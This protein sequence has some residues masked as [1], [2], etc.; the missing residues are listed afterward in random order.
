MTPAIEART[1]TWASK[2]GVEDEVDVA[3]PALESRRRRQLQAEA[4]S[5]KRGMIDGSRGKPVRGRS[6][7]RKGA[8]WAER[9]LQAVI[10]RH[11]PS[12]RRI[13]DARSFPLGIHWD[14]YGV[15]RGL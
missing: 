13:A 9:Q 2:Y 14:Y 10:E 4:R 11:E 1:R 12:V 7:A 15:A 6:N 8:S 5:N 3:V